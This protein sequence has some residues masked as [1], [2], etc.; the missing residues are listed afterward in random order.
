[1][2]HRDRA[3]A[4]LAVGRD[5]AFPQP[6]GR[7]ELSR[8]LPCKDGGPFP[9]DAPKDSVDQGPEVHGFRVSL[10]QTV[11]GVDGGVRRD[12]EKQQLG[13][14]REQDLEGR[15]CLVRERSLGNEDRDQRLE[16]AETAQG[17]ADDRAREASVARRERDGAERF[18]RRVIDRSPLFSSRCAR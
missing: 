12:I 1:M 4:R 14:A 15:A 5:P 2:R 9:R 10:R 7:V 6:I 16:L 8:I 17:G 18:S 13:R 11:G 3:R